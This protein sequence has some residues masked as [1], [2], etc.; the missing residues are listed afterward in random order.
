M[1]RDLRRPDRTGR[2]SLAPRASSR[3]YRSSS[4]AAANPTPSGTSVIAPA[5]SPSRDTHRA[6]PNARRKAPR[7]PPKPGPRRSWQLPQHGEHRTGQPIKEPRTR[8]EPG[9]VLGQIVLGRSRRGNGG[10]VKRF[11][12]NGGEVA[13]AGRPAPSTRADRYIGLVHPA[14]QVGLA[15]AKV[16]GDPA[17]GSSRWQANSTARC[18]NS[19]GLAAEIQDSS[20][21]ET[22]P[23]RCPR[24]RVRLSWRGA[25]R[26]VNCSPTPPLWPVQ[27]GPTAVL[28]QVD[29][30][31]RRVSVC[32]N[33]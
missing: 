7:P 13:E 15:H 28:S 32:R 8:T 26:G 3:S 21:K 24:N 27:D 22:M 6:G 19:G 5:C 23:P 4:T 11:E 31:V 14:P 1:Q 17:D 18:R 16:L 9:P 12:L 2:P 29:A 10:G 33:A 25:D 30:T 20:S